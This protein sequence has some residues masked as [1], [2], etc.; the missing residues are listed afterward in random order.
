LLAINCGDP[1]RLVSEPAGD[2]EESAP[3]FTP[4]QKED[5]DM[6][7]DIDRSAIPAKNQLTLHELAEIL[8]GLAIDTADPEI[9]LVEL[10]AG[11]IL[12]SQGD[13]ADFMYLLVAGALGVRVQHDDG[14]ETVIDK[15]APGAIVG[16]MALLSGQ[17]RSATVYALV[18][19]GLMCLTQS[20]LAQIEKA[21]VENGESVTAA[22]IPRWQ[23]I[24]LAHTLR[25]L[26][27]DLDTNALHLLQEQL[28]WRRYAN[29]DVI[30]RQGD[31]GDGMYIVI[32]GRLR[33]TAVTGTGI[34]TYI[35]DIQPGQTVGEYAL[36]TEEDRTATVHAVRESSVACLSPEVF[37]QLIANYPDLVVRITRIIIERRQQALRRK[38]V[39]APPSLTLALVPAGPTVDVWQFAQE[40]SSALAE[41]GST[42]ALNDEQFDTW[43]EQPGQAQIPAGDPRGLAL[44][45][46]LDELETEVKYLLFVA[47]RTPTEWT[48]RCLGRADRVLIIADP[49]TDPAPGAVEQL[50]AK[51]DIPLRRELV[52]WHPPE[53][54]K[55][56]GTMAWLDPRP[57]HTHYH[58]RQADGAHMARLA[59]RLC[60]KAIALVLSG[61]SARGYAH[62]GV[63]R[64][65]EELQIPVDYIG[66][67][68]MGAVMGASIATY[69]SNAQMMAISQKHADS[70]EIFDPTLPLA[71]VMASQK[72]TQLTQTIFGEARIEDLWVPFFCIAANL[73]TGEPV[74]FQHGPLWRAVRSSLSIPGIFTPVI[75]DGETIVDGAVM[76]NFP[77]AT[78][79]RLCESE[80]IIG[81]NVTPLK[82]K[83]RYYDYESSIS[84]WRILFSRLNPFTK[85]LRA[86]SLV[87]TMMRTMEINSLRRSKEDE[88]YVSLMI[89]PDVKGIGP[90]DYDQFETI[91]QK[92]YAAAIA[93]LRDWKATHLNA[94]E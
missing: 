39:A 86:P 21:E 54:E 27:G 5:S 23:R 34:E 88:A 36:F 40:L 16:E 63:Q 7:Q 87:T 64:A 90:Q 83:K 20:T 30:F 13:P 59:R 49:R 46:R 4:R 14:T 48:K 35:G 72:V 69:E 70:A 62:L 26:F 81:V 43:M 94:Q 78:M 82:E 55:P 47:D 76:D 6:A 12:F 57:V 92:G 11:Q 38:K 17:P 42:Q 75:E 93:P 41:H 19:A 22:A 25:G 65:F 15:L 8:D 58:V 52:L 71:A 9:R 66:G 45:A 67:T 74:V 50:L 33:I 32:L 80:C 28:E 2:R 3:N 77:A 79:A 61:G 53:T 85:S 24:H 91:T 51:M 84:G 56:Q 1:R 29:G 37:N 10:K 68:S 60:G 18:D 73:T 44:S 31:P 89:Y